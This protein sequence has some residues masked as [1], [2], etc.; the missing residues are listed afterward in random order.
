MMI[1]RAIRTAVLWLL[2]FSICAM[3]SAETVVGDPSA[4]FAG[5]PTLELDGSTYRLNRR[6]TTILLM[7]VDKTVQ[8]QMEEATFRNG[9]QADFLALI[10]VNDTEKTI[11]VIQINR[12]TMVELKVLNVVGDEI[13]TRTGQLC[14]SYAFGDGGETS[15]ELTADAVSAYLNNTPI[16]YYVSMNLDGIVAFNDALGGV[17]VTL[18]EDFSAF[19]PEMT[20]GKTMVLHG[21][22][23]EYFARSRLHVGD[24]SNLARLKRQRA[25]INAATKVLQ[26]HLE[27]NPKYIRTLHAELEPYLNMSLSRGAFYNLADK[28]GR[29]ELQPIVEIDGETR[30][31]EFEYVEF[32]PDEDALKRAIVDVLY[33]KVS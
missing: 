2:L 23:A 31:G 20:A 4:R 5:I 27:A 15:C 25:Y 17:E 29:Y 14:L 1:R 12:D 10:V 26:E 28:A 18:E 9:G 6:L 13:G 33:E 8:Q 7:G 21:K 19:D 22:Q 32:Y 24:Q 16:D 30:V 11:S 3:C